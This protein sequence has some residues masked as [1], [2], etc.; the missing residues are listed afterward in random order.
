MRRTPLRSTLCSQISDN[1]LFIEQIT[2]RGVVLLLIIH[3]LSKQPEEM[4]R[5][6]QMALHTM[7]T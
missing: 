1:L 2:G 4:G 6:E 5:V 7:W 3:V